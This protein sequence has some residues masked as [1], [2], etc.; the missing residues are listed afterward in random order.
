[1]GIFIGAKKSLT[2]DQMIKKMDPYPIGEFVDE[3]HNNRF[4]IH[5][6]IKC[7][8]DQILLIIVY[9]VKSVTRFQENSCKYWICLG[10]F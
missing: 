6:Q 2:P 1:M 3:T 8:I 5:Y 4:S 7:S 10:A 9:E